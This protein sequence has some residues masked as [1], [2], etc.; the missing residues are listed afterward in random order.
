MDITQIQVAEEKKQRVK[1]MES[2]FL[3]L[4]YNI[5]E[6]MISISWRI[7]QISGVLCLDSW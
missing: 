3:N 2:A 5:T 4:M 1:K 6:L 7:A